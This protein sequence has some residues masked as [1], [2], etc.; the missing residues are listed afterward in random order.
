VAFLHAAK[1]AYTLFAFLREAPNVQAAVSKL[2][3][4]GEIWLDTTVI[5]P[6][7]AEHLVDPAQRNYR[8]LFEAARAAGVSPRTTFG[9]VEEILSHLDRCRAAIVSAPN[10]VGDHLSSSMLTYGAE[11]LSATSPRST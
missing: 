9:V 8:R 11:G 4:G 2:F 3:S 1:E 6:L 5:L 10:S 7:L